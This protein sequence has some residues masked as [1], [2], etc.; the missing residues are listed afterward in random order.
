MV[1]SRGLK[2][3]FFFEQCVRDVSSCHG[4]LTDIFDFVLRSAEV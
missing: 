4:Q 2:Y 3:A 1:G